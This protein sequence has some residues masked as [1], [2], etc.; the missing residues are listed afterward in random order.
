VYLVLAVL[1]LV[2]NRAAIRA[3]LPGSHR[4]APVAG[5]GES[6]PGSQIGS[7]GETPHAR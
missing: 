3:Y 2:A 4:P 5:A 6:G 7:G 1:L